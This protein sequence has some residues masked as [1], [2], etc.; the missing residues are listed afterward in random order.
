MTLEL[1]DVIAQIGGDGGGGGPVPSRHVYD[2]GDMP[3][4]P[5]GNSEFL[6]PDVPEGATLVA[7]LEW[8][9]P[10]TG[11]PAV[12]MEHGD[13]ATLGATFGPGSGFLPITVVSTASGVGRGTFIFIAA[14]EGYTATSLTVIIIPAINEST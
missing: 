11:G 14:A 4:D 5:G 12:M 2:L 1:G 10:E 9:G 8:A 6:V 13:D 3:I 7:S